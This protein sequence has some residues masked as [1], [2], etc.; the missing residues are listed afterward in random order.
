MLENI[1]KD[2]LYSGSIQHAFSEASQKVAIVINSSDLYAKYLSVL[3]YSLKKFSKKNNYYDIIILSDDMSEKNIELNSCYE[4]AN[5][6]IRYFNPSS[7]FD[8]KNITVLVKKFSKANYYRMI[9]PALLSNYDYIICMEVDMVVNSDIMCIISDIKDIDKRPIAVVT[10]PIALGC[11]YSGAHINTVN[12]KMPL[13]EYLKDVLGITDPMK[14]FNTG[15]FVF[16]VRIVNEGGYVEKLLSLMEH[17]NYAYMDQDAY[18]EMF[19]NNYAQLDVRYNFIPQANVRALL[20]HDNRLSSLVV[21]DVNQVKVIHWAGRFKPWGNPYFLYSS[22]WWQ[23]ALY[24]PYFN[25]EST[26]HNLFEKVLNYSQS[27]QFMTKPSMVLNSIMFEIFLEN[28]LEL[29]FIGNG[30]CKFRFYTSNVSSKTTFLI[31]YFLRNSRYVVKNFT[32]NGVCNFHVFLN[33][34]EEFFS[35]ILNFLSL[36][37]YSLSG[38]YEDLVSKFISQTINELYLNNYDVSVSVT[39][40]NIIIERINIMPNSNFSIS[41]TPYYYGMLCFS[42]TSS[43]LCLLSSRNHLNEL[44]RKMELTVSSDEN[45]INISSKGLGNSLH[46]FNIFCSQLFKI[47]QSYVKN[48]EK[49]SAVA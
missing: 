22:L 49:E 41:V 12:G 37:Y 29:S 7:L 10:C 33:D 47:W 43:N 11:F 17:K 23:Y 21:D 39:K 8:D 6:S 19:T 27:F 38:V 16:N 45:T 35:D 42:F 30:V 25:I 46:D 4:S 5:F 15:L 31:S 3:L 20:K 9:A 13:S 1:S 32:D 48:T 36:S 34:F 28:K 44:I 40:L 14:Y 2:S 26:L 24:T 18:S